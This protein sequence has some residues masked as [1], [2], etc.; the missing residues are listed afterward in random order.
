[1][2]HLLFSFNFSHGGSE[3][4]CFRVVMAVFIAQDGGIES[5]ELVERAGN[6]VSVRS[7]VS[8]G[9]GTST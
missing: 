2:E 1:M 8:V 6:L 9:A 7:G 5:D 3:K 4:R